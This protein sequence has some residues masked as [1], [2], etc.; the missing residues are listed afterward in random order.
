MSKKKPAA[1][2]TTAP[3]SPGAAT[4]GALIPVNSEHGALVPLPSGWEIAPVA[5]LGLV[6]YSD[7]A[8][9]TVHARL[10]HCP[11]ATIADDGRHYLSLHLDV[12]IT[13]RQSRA[14]NRAVAGLDAAGAQADGASNS[15]GRVIQRG[16][17]IRWLLDRLA[18]EL[19]VGD[20]L[21]AGSAP[22]PP[23]PPV[24]LDD[25]TLGT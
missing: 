9:R 18:D 14:L 3:E 20:L 23:T 12:R 11:C 24:G 15:R 2:A 6:T 19:D 22:T 13:A 5:D 7:T 25:A 8:A 1:P 17:A 16:D 21:L 4:P 10:P